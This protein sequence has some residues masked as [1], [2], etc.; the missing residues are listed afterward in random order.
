M[1]EETKAVPFNKIFLF[2]KCEI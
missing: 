2:L 1:C